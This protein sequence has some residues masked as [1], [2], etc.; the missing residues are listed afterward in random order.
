M[1]PSTAAIHSARE[2]VQKLKGELERLS[3]HELELKEWQHTL[4]GETRLDQV[5]RRYF[6]DYATDRVNNMNDGSDE[7][8]TRKMET[9]DRSMKFSVFERLFRNHRNNNCAIKD[10][11]FAKNILLHSRKDALRKTEEQRRE[12]FKRLFEDALIREER[13]RN[14]E[15]MTTEQVREKEELKHCTFAPKILKRKPKTA[16]PKR[17]AMN[18]EIAKSEDGSFAY[19]DFLGSEFSGC[20]VD[21][22][23]SSLEAK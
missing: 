5:M 11:I 23:A 18:R 22:A 20:S 4:R 3:Q 17:E 6:A 7:Y 9:E 16:R 10:T 15:M 13:A 14:D 1:S 19:S 21:Q 2:E 12:I 8:A